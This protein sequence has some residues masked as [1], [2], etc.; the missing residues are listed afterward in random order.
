[1]SIV[2]GCP[3]S[4]IGPSLLLLPVLGTVSPN[5]SHPH[6]L[7]QFSKVVSRLFSLGIHS[8]DF[9]RNFCSACAVTIVIFGQFTRSFS[10]TYCICCR[11]W[12]VCATQLC[13]AFNTCPPRLSSNDALNRL[14]AVG[15]A[16]DWFPTC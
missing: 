1:M 15:L 6:P 3:P 2:H 8:C 9:C 10:F 4:A 12:T 14:T 13:S 11:Q 16:M 5:I 7:Y